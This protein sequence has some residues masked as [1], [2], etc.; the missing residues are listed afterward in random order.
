MYVN[1]MKD[2]KT[3]QFSRLPKQQLWY[4]DGCVAIS[5]CLSTLTLCEC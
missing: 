4:I 1:L 2:L 5:V 3:Y